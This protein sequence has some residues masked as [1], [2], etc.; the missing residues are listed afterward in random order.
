MTIENITPSASELAAATEI[1]SWFGEI[2]SNG[3]IPDPDVA[4]II[5]K[6]I[7]QH[8][9]QVERIGFLKGAIEGITLY[10]IW[11][12]GEQLVGCME[13]PLQEVLAPYKEEL[14]RLIN[15]NH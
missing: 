8:E 5:A 4:S 2:R 14:T 1:L 7:R 9:E 3:S 10:A 11:R 12:N 6:H 15:E 13:K